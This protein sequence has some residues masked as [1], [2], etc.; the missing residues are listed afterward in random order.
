MNKCPK[1]G[2]T[3]MDIGQVIHPLG[4]N[5]LHLIM[6]AQ[7]VNN[8]NMRVI[9]CIKCKACGHSEFVDDCDSHQL[10]G[11]KVKLRNLR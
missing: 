1:C 7:R 4:N 9:Y 10:G 3:E 8:T 5:E 2:S 11:E 6:Q